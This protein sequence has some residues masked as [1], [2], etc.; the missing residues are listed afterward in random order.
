[1]VQQNNLWLQW[2]L[3]S[4]E[5]SAIGPDRAGKSVSFFARR[6]RA[7]RSMNKLISDPKTR[8]SDYVVT[9]LTMAGLIETRLDNT[10]SSHIHMADVRDLV[11]SRYV[12]HG[13]PMQVSFA[14]FC[15]TT[16]IG[17]DSYAFPDTTDRKSVV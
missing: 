6:A 7:Y 9:G 15:N 8:F 16:R 5:M 14:T 11:R 10:S 17:L 4:A 1:M 13:V 3:L 12:V 2:T